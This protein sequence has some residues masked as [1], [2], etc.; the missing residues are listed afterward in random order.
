MLAMGSV[1]TNAFMLRL[2]LLVVTSIHLNGRV[3]SVRL[4]VRCA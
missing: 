2:S 4:V 1:K 3:G